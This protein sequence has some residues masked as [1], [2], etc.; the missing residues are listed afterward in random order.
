MCHVQALLN[1]PH[2][3][4]RVDPLAAGATPGS[5]PRAG[6]K[7]QRGMEHFFKSSA[8]CLSCRRA[9][10]GG[11]ADRGLCDSCRGEDGTRERTWLGLLRE[12]ERMERKRGLAFATCARCHSGGL[13]GAVVCENGECPVLYSRL[14]ST[15]QLHALDDS[16]ARLLHEW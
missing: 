7:Q 8:K 14:S 4:V 6:G 16:M 12:A 3:R 9:V 1:G 13:Q 5:K 11:G 15:S 10:P 2:T